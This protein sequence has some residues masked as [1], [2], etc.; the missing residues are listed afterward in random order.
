M[1]E[2]ADT[3]PIIMQETVPVSFDDTPETVSLRVL[4]LEHGMLPKAVALMA[5]GKLEVVG[6]KVNILE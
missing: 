3:G 1:D 6:K 2:G 4:K 5:D